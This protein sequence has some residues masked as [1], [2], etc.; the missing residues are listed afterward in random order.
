[1]M[2]G[3]FFHILSSLLVA[4]FAVCILTMGSAA[5]DEVEKVER[6]TKYTIPVIHILLLMMTAVP[7]TKTQRMKE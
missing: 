4:V 1:M 7:L 5:A 3:K 6:E 2:K